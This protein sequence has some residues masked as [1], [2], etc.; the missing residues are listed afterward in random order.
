[1]EL[2]SEGGKKRY[3]YLSDS[4]KEYNILVVDTAE[5]LSD[6]LESDAVDTYRYNVTDTN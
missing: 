4:N 1:M 5:A 3:S 2:C 6:I